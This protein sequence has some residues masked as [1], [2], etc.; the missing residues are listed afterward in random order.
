MNTQTLDFN[1]FTI[2]YLK[3]G[4]G[5]KIFV[6]L[7]GISIKSVM[8]SASAIEKDYTSIANEY[9]TYVI[10]RRN[11]PDENTTIYSMA[12]DTLKVLDKLQ[13]KD[14]YLFGASQGGMLAMQIALKR[15]E[16]RKKMVFGSTSATIENNMI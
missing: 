4:K 2:D 14:I 13:L 15:P 12:E 3:F 1:D 16:R 6:I 7:P 10:E 9:T 5:D 11:N 8:L